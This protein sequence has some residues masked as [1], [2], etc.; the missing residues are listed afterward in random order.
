MSRRKE[1][2]DRYLAHQ[3]M[4]GDF[5]IAVTLAAKAARIEA[6]WRR[7]PDDQPVRPDGFFGLRFPTLPDGRNR[8]FFCL[9]ADRSTM[10][11]ERFLAKLHAYQAWHVT[12]GHTAV[13]ASSRFG[14]SRSRRPSNG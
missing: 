2:G 8:A 4:I 5:R 11:R 9:E 12:G 14:F 7:F 6:T 13:L 1:V 3:L 10:P